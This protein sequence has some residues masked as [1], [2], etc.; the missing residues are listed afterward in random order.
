MFDKLFIL[1]EAGV[2][3]NGDINLAYKLIDAAHRAGADGIKFQ[4]YVT[5]E[6]IARGTAKAPYQEA[7]G[8]GEDQFQMLKRLELSFDAFKKLKAYADAKGMLFVSTPFDEKSFAFLSTLDMPFWKIPSGEITNYLFLMAAG[9]TGKPVVLSTGMSTLDEVGAAI[10]TLQEHG[11]RD[12]TLLHCTTAYPTP[13]SEVNLRSM[14]TLQETFDLPVGYSDHTL[15]STAAI[16]AVSRGAIFLEKH[17]TLDQSLPG[18]DHAASITPQ[19]LSLYIRAARDTAKLLGS[20]KKERT[21][22]E[23]ENLQAARKS[24]V[25]GKAIA[26]GTPFS[27]ASLTTRRPATGVSPMY[28]PQLI[29]L[30]AQK[31][32]APGDFIDVEEISTLL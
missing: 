23:E 29:K 15:G 19:E 10:K 26:K 25:A 28:Y 27:E 24:L 2:N 18:P 6:L 1:A 16:A 8:G 3:H 30:K 17:F 32:Y 14:T 22:H 5:E 9:Q 12:L 21:A 7:R 13:L 4:T 11:N 31:D 20:A